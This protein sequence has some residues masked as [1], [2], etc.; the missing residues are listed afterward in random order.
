MELMPAT[1]DSS[2]HMLMPSTDFPL[3]GISSQALTPVPTALVLSP[4][5]WVIVVGDVHILPLPSAPRIGWGMGT[6]RLGMYPAASKSR[7]AGQHNGAFGR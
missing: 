4:V 2:S 3:L 6:G 5:S 7:A 1:W